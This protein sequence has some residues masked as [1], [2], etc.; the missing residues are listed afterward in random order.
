MKKDMQTKKEQRKKNHTKTKDNKQS[1]A[2]LVQAKAC[3]FYIR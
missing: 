2:D 1:P 3:F